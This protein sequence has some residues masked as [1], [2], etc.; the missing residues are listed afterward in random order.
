[1]ISFLSILDS[2]PVNRVLKPVSAIY[3]AVQMRN[4]HFHTPY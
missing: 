2:H 1:M 3:R 4:S